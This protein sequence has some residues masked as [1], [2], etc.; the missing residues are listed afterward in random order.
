MKLLVYLNKVLPQWATFLF[1]IIILSFSGYFPI[2]AQN[3]SKKQISETDYDKWGSL[4]T[5]ST[6]ATGKWVSY[7]MDYKSKQDTL[8]VQSTSGLKKYIIPAGTLGNFIEDSYFACMIPGAKLQL[9]NLS[10]GAITVI[11]NVMRYELTTYGKFI[12]VSDEWYGQQS[13]LKIYNQNAKLIDSIAGV[14]E[15][16]LNDQTNEMVYVAKSN[17]RY[18]MG[19]VNFS[20]YKKQLLPQN[21]LT[22]FHQLVWQKNGKSFVY[23][24]EIDSVAKTQVANYYNIEK[25]ALYKLEKF[26]NGTKVITSR[27]PMVISDDGRFVVIGMTNRPTVLNKNAVEI[28]NGNDQK[29]FSGVQS[30]NYVG[31]AIT[32]IRWNP[33][34]GGFKQISSDSLPNAMI[35]KNMSYALISNV[36]QYSNIPFYHPKTDYYIKSIQSGKEQL[37]LERQSSDPQRVVFNPEGNMIVYYQQKNWWVYDVSQGKRLNLTKGKEA[38]WDNDSSA[39]EGVPT[40]FKVY[41]IAGWVND[42]KNMLLYDEFD[43]WLVAFDGSIFIRLTEG[44]E[45][46]LVYRIANSEFQ[47]RNGSYLGSKNVG[48]NLSKGMLLN[49]RSQDDWSSGFALYS[50]AHGVRSIVFG[51]NKYDGIKRVNSGFIYTSENFDL[52]PQLAFQGE[53]DVQ[54]ALLYQ[55]NRH[56]QDFQYG[57]SELIRYKNEDG[58][59]LKAAIFYPANYDTSKKYPMIVNIYETTSGYVNS[60]N[61]P[62]LLNYEGFNNSSCTLNGYIV[63]MPDIRYRLGD[64]GLSAKK[65]VVAAV[66]TVIDMGIV[67]PDK[68][69]LIGHSFGGY[70]TNFIISQTNLFAAAVSGAGISDLV[71][72][73]FN[74]D[75]IWFFKPD[76]WR[77]ED[78]QY[79][80]GK[81]LYDHKDGYLRNSPIMQVD[82]IKTPLLLWSGKSDRVVPFVQSISMYLAMRRLEKKTVLLA[83]PNEDHSLRAPVNQIDLSKRMADWFDYYLKDVKPPDWIVKGTQ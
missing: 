66:K 21:S 48:L 27:T 57:K 49:V 34:S 42:Q 19:T 1:V 41:G 51:K 46:Q 15:Y 60:Y 25:Q 10:S 28:W 63:L 14:T 13:D 67:L 58:D 4:Y 33:E 8:F 3:L 71:G 74:L 65:S 45:K 16:K 22:K 79:R 83:Y 32:L 17:G 44:R 68:I 80:M 9:L 7:E 50:T 24:T 78:Q 52:P 39:Y 11:P 35:N 47:D 56:Q 53:Y 69:G 72:H 2:K 30:L 23:L 38:S 70:E 64:P 61:N 62:S 54:S 36:N 5:K 43:L 6:S 37:L 26:G 31:G 75:E 76:M 40:S 77:Y 82:K 81:S 55:S 12:I 73:Y 29:L 18:E 20:K 59:S